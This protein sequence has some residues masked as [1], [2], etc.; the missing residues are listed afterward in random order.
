[1]HSGVKGRSK[2]QWARNTLAKNILW[3]FAGA[4]LI[5]QQQKPIEADMPSFRK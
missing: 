5:G 4:A 1:M 3:F 2:A